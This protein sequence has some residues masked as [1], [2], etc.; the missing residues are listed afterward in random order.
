[1]KFEHFAGSTNV[2]ACGQGWGWEA[3][4]GR[5]VECPQLERGA[6]YKVRKSKGAKE[7]KGERVKE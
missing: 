2:H 6:H 4:Q 1:M 5:V 3:D 7:Q